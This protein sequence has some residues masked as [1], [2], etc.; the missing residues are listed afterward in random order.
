MSLREKLGRRAWI[1]DVRKTDY[2]LGQIEDDHK[3]LIGLLLFL[4]MGVVQEVP[5]HRPAI[6]SKDFL[7]RSQ[8]DAPPS[9]SRVAIAHTYP[10]RGIQLL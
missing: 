8:S 6:P 4:E 9:K 10:T 7:S 1:M 5:V 3:T 2:N